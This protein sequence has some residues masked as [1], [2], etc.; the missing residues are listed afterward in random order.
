MILAGLDSSTQEKI[1]DACKSKVNPKTA[2]APVTETA[3]CKAA[4]YF[5]DA[6]SMA[7]LPDERV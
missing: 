5:R 2:L 6:N 3:I 4:M 1:L 7:D